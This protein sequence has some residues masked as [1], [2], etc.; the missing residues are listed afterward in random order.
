MATATP[1][2]GLIK[3]SPGEKYSVGTTNGNLDKLDNEPVIK[4]YGASS[5]NGQVY[6]GSITLTKGAGGESPA[7]ANATDGYGVGGIW[8]ADLSGLPTPFKTITSVQITHLQDS[9]EFI[10][11][12]ALRDVTTTR[13]KFQARRMQTAAWANGY[14]SMT[15]YVMIA[16]TA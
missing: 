6:I 9:Q 7:A 15:L 2:R 5:S 10:S 16:G 3:A 11:S 14:G 8:L 13:I 1:R 12:A 4:V